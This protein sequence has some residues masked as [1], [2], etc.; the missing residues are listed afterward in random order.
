MV[1][2]SKQNTT[3]S[4]HL[5]VPFFAT[6]TLKLCLYE[7]RDTLLLIPSPFMPSSQGDQ[8]HMSPLKTLFKVVIFKLHE[9]KSLRCSITAA[10]RSKTQKW[11]SDLNMPAVDLF[12][13]EIH[14]LSLGPS[15]PCFKSHELLQTS[16]SL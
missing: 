2:Q 11:T 1:T 13:S 9:T 5:H 12:T 4:V 7:T 15:Y 3:P 6:S 8:I 14:C 16:E 10:C